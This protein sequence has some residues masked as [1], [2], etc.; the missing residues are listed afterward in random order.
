VVRSVGVNQPA[1]N[2]HHALGST[3]LVLELPL[4]MMS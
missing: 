2:L 4:H 1:L 3:G